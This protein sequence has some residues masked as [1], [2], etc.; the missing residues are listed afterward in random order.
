MK[1]LGSLKEFSKILKDTVIPL[2]REDGFKGT[3]PLFQWLSPHLVQVIHFQGARGGG[4]CY[5]NIGIDFTFRHRDFLNASQ[6]L[7]AE[8]CTFND[9]MRWQGTV[10][11]R[12]QLWMYTHESVERMVEYYHAE[13]RPLLH[14]FRQFPEAF[15]VQSVK[16]LLQE[17]EF[18]ESNALQRVRSTGELTIAPQKSRWTFRYAGGL[19]LLENRLC[20]PVFRQ[21]IARL[22][23]E[24]AQQMQ[25]PLFCA[26]Y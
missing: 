5:I 16:E 10:H 4:A 23:A 25:N 2:F 13:I 6:K 14:H 26:S 9:R 19:S 3:M 8:C 12:E 20:D 22:Q 24:S 18:K 11:P 7:Y 21:K 17:G 15:Q 1:P